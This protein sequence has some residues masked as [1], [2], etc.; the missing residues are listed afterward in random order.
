VWAGIKLGAEND[1]RA[2]AGLH[3]VE[4]QSAP[5]NGGQMHFMLIYDVGPDFIERRTQFR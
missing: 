3:I 4:M 2:R 1:R 5:H